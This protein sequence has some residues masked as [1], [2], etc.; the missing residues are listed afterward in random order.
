MS[1]YVEGPVTV[2]VPATSANL[3]PGF[4]SFGLALDYGDTLTAEVVGSGLEIDVV[5]EG[6]DS[7]PRTADHLVVRAMQHAFDEM[8]VPLPG[9][10]LSCVNRIAHS[11]G[12]GSS[13]AAI[14]GG[15]RLAV[16]LV[17][18]DAARL[19]EWAMLELANRIEGH[20]DNV[21]PALLGGLVIAGTSDDGLWVHRA[22][23]HEGLDLALFIP[24]HGLDTEVARGLIP[25]EVPHRVAAANGARTAMLALGLTQDPALLLRGTEDFLHQE[26]RTAGMPDSLALVHRLRAAGIPAVVSGA[27]PTVLAF[28]AREG[29]NSVDDVL[30]QAPEG[31]RG[32]AHRAADQGV[33]VSPTVADSS[34]PRHSQP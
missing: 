21:A 26:Q 2:E 28:V 31:W 11:R 5:G 30:A 29:A 22:A 32:E 24:P 17:A 18:D 33:R 6:A 23:V 16:A 3:G 9:L 27:G 34:T 19:D 12:M 25:D 10:R 13:S 7:V 15:I 20:P 4:D 14:V 1:L 8:G